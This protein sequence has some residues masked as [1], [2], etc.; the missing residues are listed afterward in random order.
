MQRVVITGA[1][2][3][4]G[5]Q[6]AKNLAKRG[7][8][9]LVLIGRE[10]E[11]SANRLTKARDEVERS[12]GSAAVVVSAVPCDF[13]SLAD[14]RRAASAVATKHKKIDALLLNAAV[15]GK[16]GAA[17]AQQ[18]AGDAA[19]HA[20]TV[21][22]LSQ[23]LLARLLL[24]ALRESRQ[25]GRCVFVSSELHRNTSPLP[26]TPSALFERGGRGEG[27]GAAAA[28]ASSPSSSPP[29]RAIYASTKLLN[30][31]SAREMQRREPPASTVRFSAA[32]PGFV[33][34][35]GLSRNAAGSGVAAW[36]FRALAPW[37]PFAVSLDEGARRLEAALLGGGEEEEA[38]QGG[39]GALYYT[40][41]APSEPSAAAADDAMAAEAWRMT[42]ERLGA[43][44][45]APLP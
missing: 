28:A 30:I 1:T 3:G 38:P 22:H 36:A 16:G 21:N 10:G 7:G 39:G 26:A 42:E 35:T 11:G 9:E 33:P 15:W 32:S 37:L 8:F 25:G 13:G 20:L 17:S 29:P 14:V 23:F 45:L 5:L 12:S 41:G 18:E 43:E 24:P 31:W 40:K 4:L 27:E 2:G 34:N 6:V 19:E 44:L